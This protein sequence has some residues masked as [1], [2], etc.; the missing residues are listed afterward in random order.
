MA[1][2]PVEADDDGRKV[3]RPI[4]NFN[5]R[6]VIDSKSSRVHDDDDDGDDGR[7]ATK[8]GAKTEFEEVEIGG[9]KYKVEKGGVEALRA[10]LKPK[11]P[12]VSESQ[13]IKKMLDEYTAKLQG[14]KKKKAVEQDEDEDDDTLS[15]D[16]LFTDTK[17]WMKDFKKSL[18]KDI[19]AAVSGAYTQDQSHKEFW[20]DFYRT[21]SDLKDYDFIV[22]AVMSKNAA[23]LSPMS[24]EEGSDR[25]AELAREQL[26]NIAKKVSKGK[27]K[28][29]KFHVEGE[30]SSRRSEPDDVEDEDD[31]EKDKKA[32]MPMTMSA[33]LKDRREKR[34]LGKP[35]N[36]TEEGEE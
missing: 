36:R 14:G 19:L 5:P 25:L 22:K 11:K 3:R 23:E 6:V 34:R 17:G 18:S 31:D 16:R 10:Q 9:K 12:A 29:G 13:E 30:Q 26:L 35:L 33:L 27:S 15:D 1:K 28:N 21:N 7:P 2:E 4:V 20:G 24:T 8:K 32:G